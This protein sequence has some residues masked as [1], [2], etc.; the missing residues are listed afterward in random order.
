MTDWCD[1]NISL[2]KKTILCLWAWPLGQWGGGG[3]GMVQRKILDQ[4]LTSGKVSTRSIKGSGDIH[5]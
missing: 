4:Y 1:I 5:F 2:N 3:M